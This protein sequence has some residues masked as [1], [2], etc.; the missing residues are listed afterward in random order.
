ML[1]LAVSPNLHFSGEEDRFDDGGRAKGRN[2]WPT[3]VTRLPPR[4]SASDGRMPDRMGVGKKI[5]GLL[6]VKL[7]PSMLTLSVNVSAAWES[8]SSGG[9]VQRRCWLSR[10]A[11]EGALT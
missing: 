4:G 2:R 1:P 10:K 5:K 11:S 6:E 3:T 8:R 9:V 7:S